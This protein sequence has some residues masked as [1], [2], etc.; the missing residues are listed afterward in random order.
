MALISLSLPHTHTCTHTHMRTH[1]QTF[2]A[3]HQVE[4][5]IIITF[6]LLVL[7]HDKM[8]N[9]ANIWQHANHL[10]KGGGVGGGMTTLNCVQKAA[11]FATLSLS[12]LLWTALEQPRPHQLT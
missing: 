10:K 8:E 11:A 1:A 4:Y 3:H 5:V 6:I 12:P 7:P 9:G 2:Q